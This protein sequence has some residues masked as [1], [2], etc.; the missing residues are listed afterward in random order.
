MLSFEGSGI[1]IN[2]TLIAE[3]SPALFW[4]LV[5]QYKEKKIPCHQM[6]LE[7]L[8]KDDWTHLDDGRVRKPSMKAMENQRQ[9]TEEAVDTVVFAMVVHDPRFKQA[10]SLI[11]ETNAVSLRHR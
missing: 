6:L 5:F 10:M 3:R 4:P 11:T 9:E 1:K 2:P 7:I 8:T